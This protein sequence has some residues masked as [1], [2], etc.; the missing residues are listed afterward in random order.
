MNNSQKNRQMKFRLKYKI[1]LP[2]VI[3]SIGVLILI[4]A[5][6]VSKIKAERITTIHT[7]FHN[8]LT[9]IDFALTNFFKI[10]ESDL[11]YITSNEFVQ[12]RG[13]KDF[14]NFVDSDE[15]TFKYDTGD[16][17][18]NIIHIFDTYRQT[19]PYIN[20]IYLGRENGSLVR[21]HKQ[22][23]PAPYDPRGQ[24]WYIL[25]KE[26]PEKVMRND[27]Y[28]SVTTADINIEIV[29]A[30]L[31]RQGKVYGVVGMDVTLVNLMEY[32]QNIHVGY[33][34]WM[35][36]IDKKGTIL[37]SR[38]KDVLFK[39]IGDIEQ[40][41]LDHILEEREGFTTF[42]RHSQERYVYFYESPQL[43]WK[44]AF[45]L[46]VDEIN[47]GAYSFVRM[48]IF[49]L[50][51]SLILLGVITLVGI[52]KFVI[53]PIKKLEDHTKLIRCT[54]NL[55]Q[56]IELRS[57]D[58]FESLAQS[59]NRM[60]SSIKEANMALIK[61]EEQ[62]RMHRERLEELVKVRTAELRKINKDLT[63]EI[64]ERKNAEEALA[65]S[66]KLLRRQYDILIKK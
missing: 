7:S 62:L 37:A 64:T 24:P 38:E 9:H 66:E 45:I 21:S 60:L 13:D 2:Y 4:G 16:Q 51:I 28:R 40:K 6:L 17:E 43:S 61:S 11:E 36:L 55:E 35:A 20:S 29:K 54:G 1:S 39:N 15:T 10:I 22:A 14:S 26:N 49:I 18:Q 32:I 57:G 30:L 8:Q 44:L 23:M 53:S 33:G 34:G 42:T 5:F 48:I 41:G 52:Q 59:C 31:D 46:P 65:Q 58:E 12:T 25:A 19:H 63:E 50:S 27:P 56:H 47:G 3:S